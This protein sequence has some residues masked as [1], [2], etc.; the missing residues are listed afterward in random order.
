MP[1]EF[2]FSIDPER[3]IDDTYA[4]IICNAINSKECVK[5]IDDEKCTRC[6]QFDLNCIKDK[7]KPVL[8]N[9]R[10]IEDEIFEVGDIVYAWWWNKKVQNKKHK[11]K[12]IK[13]HPDKSCDIQYKD[14][15]KKELYVMTNYIQHIDE[16][17]SDEDESDED[18]SDEESDEEESD[19]EQ[20]EPFSPA[21]HGNI[22]NCTECKRLKQKCSLTNN[23]KKIPCE[24]CVKSGKKCIPTE[25]KK[26]GRKSKSEFTYNSP[27]STRI[28]SCSSSDIICSG[29]SKP[30]HRNLMMKCDFCPKSY[31]SKCSGNKKSEFS[32]DTKWK[33]KNCWKADNLSTNSGG[34][35]S[36]K[37]R[38]RPSS[39]SK[40]VPG[41]PV[42]K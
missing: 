38:G 40:R 18:E 39:D 20:V 5:Y 13:V 25:R 41:R 10:E 17:E 32:A 12:I 29:C 9:N 24:R 16:E 28:I 14:D 30:F 35:S 8:G 3:T 19:E 2:V 7:K 31:C 4:C 15:N 1:S 11:A 42:K 6:L 33:C 22:G 34:S 21:E 36:S 23:P 26:R 37:K 27:K